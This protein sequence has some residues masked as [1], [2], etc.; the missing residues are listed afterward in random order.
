MEN[1]DTLITGEEIPSDNFD[2]VCCKYYLPLELEKLD[3]RIRTRAELRSVGR[4]L[5][6]QAEKD[7]DLYQRLFCKGSFDG[8]F[9]IEYI[10]GEWKTIH[11]T[12]PK[13]M[14]A[15]HVRGDYWIGLKSPWYPIFCTLDIDNPG[16]TKT[17][18]EAIKRKLGLHEKQIAAYTSPSFFKDDLSHSG[19]LHLFIKPTFN[20]N[21][22]TQKLMRKILS[23]LIQE[24]HYELY[25]QEKKVCRLPFGRN[26]HIVD[27][28][29]VVDFDSGWQKSLREVFGLIPVPLEKFPY[30]K[31][32]RRIPINPILD[33][34]PQ[35]N[36]AEEILHTGLIEYGTRHKITGLLARYFYFRNWPPDSVKTYIRQWLNEKHN[37]FSREINRG[38]WT[39]VNKEIDNW[40]NNTYQYFEQQKIY[41]TITHNLLGWVT[42][43]DIKL[44]A[45]IFPGNYINQKRLFKL[46]SYYRP[47]QQ[48][49]YVPIHREKWRKLIGN[50]GER[51][52]KRL[53]H[54]KNLID[55]RDSYQVRNYSKAYRLNRLSLASSSEMLK[56]ENGRTI[57]DYKAAL[58]KVFISPRNII[59]AT[60]ISRHTLYKK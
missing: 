20:A 42:N 50:R 29:G 39:L 36:K 60:G 41:P 53:L 38:N 15:R 8:S 9:G 48:R 25:P 2:N 24:L 1:L 19:S 59:S 31:E 22:C 12:P 54:E 32:N 33:V 47:R 26:Q 14:L 49:G 23:P 21:P 7:F 35:K 27:I 13:K 40:I 34:S 43:L 45:E 51:E 55:V 11:Y 46:I 6:E 3:S 56:D 52:F 37:G 16:D 30:Q 17:A 44:I 10:G 4:A 5:K 18:I 28:N 57:Q 58:R